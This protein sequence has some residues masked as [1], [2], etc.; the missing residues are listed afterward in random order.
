MI[1]PDSLTNEQAEK[2]GAEIAQDFGLKRSK[3]HSDRWQTENGTFTNK[4]I[5]RRA[6]SIIALVACTF[7]T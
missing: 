3:E 2:I 1:I 6:H 5:A 7:K 4:G